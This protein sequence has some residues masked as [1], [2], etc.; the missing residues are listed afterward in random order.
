MIATSNLKKRRVIEISLLLTLGSILGT[1]LSFLLSS[2]VTDRFP[3]LPDSE[4]QGTIRG[5]ILEGTDVV[6]WHVKVRNQGTQAVISLMH[7]DT[8]SLNTPLVNA[9]TNREWLLPLLVPLSTSR[10]AAVLKFVSSAHSKG[11]LQG[12]VVN[13]ALNTEGTWELKPIQENSL[14]GTSNME[15]QT[16]LSLRSELDELLAQ[17]TSRGKNDTLLSKQIEQLT[18]ENTKNETN[19]EKGVATLAR[20]LSLLAQAQ[21]EYAK[22]KK[23]LESI[24]EKRTRLVRYSSRGKLIELSNDILTRENR[25]I[26]ALFLRVS[27]RANSRAERKKERRVPIRQDILLEDEHL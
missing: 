9:G 12:V 14:K 17:L 19:K 27:R 18:I 23:L 11:P 26:D 22:E 10:G 13:T 6:R 4:Y 25:L 5:P 20:D 2:A 15:I 7:N 16:W 3:I 21:E 8:P 24:E 1:S